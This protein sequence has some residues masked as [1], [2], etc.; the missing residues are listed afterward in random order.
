MPVCKNKFWLEN[1]SDLFCE[2]DIIPLTHMSL[3][4]QLNALS[5][6]IFLIT[7]II[8]PFTGLQSIY[9]FIAGIVFIIILF[10]S[11]RNM[12][13][14]EN[15][16]PCAFNNRTAIARQTKIQ[17]NQHQSRGGLKVEYYKPQCTK[18][19]K[20][21]NVNARRPD[22]TTLAWNEII[23]GPEFVSA[24][25]ALVGKP[26][27]RT[28]IPPIRVPPPMS[29]DW[30]ENSFVVRPGINS[31]TNQDLTRSGYLVSKEGSNCTD[32]EGQKFCCGKDMNM[33]LVRSTYIPANDVVEGFEIEQKL[34]KST[35]P[36]GYLDSNYKFPYRPY[37]S[38][39]KP[40]RIKK[41][42]IS[43]A[44]YSGDVLMADGYFPDQVLDDNLPSNISFGACPKDPEFKE[45]NKQ[46]FTSTLQPGVY[47]RNQIQEPI[48]SN[49]GI[50]FTQQF[51][52]VTCDKDCNGVTF[53][54]HDPN[55]MEIPYEKPEEILP[56]DKQTH[57]SDIYDPRFTGY[58]TSYRSYVEPVTGQVR[59]YY[60][61]VDAHKRPN[62]LCRSKVDFI[63][64]SLT[65][66]PIPNTEYFNKQNRYSRTIANDAFMDDTIAFR[67]DMQERLMRKANANLQQ[68]RRFPKHTRSVSKGGMSNPRCR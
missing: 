59:F 42:E 16:Q 19:Q 57:L 62:Y 53:I 45:Y 25:Q 4:R 28:M 24:N 31:A 18:T 46:T 36:I 21:C 40:E 12:D 13:C 51:E 6:L 58:G 3:A 65:T 30:K 37:G 39:G 34:P 29:S 41:V 35:T 49:I 20:L 68:S 33:E 7:L 60:D 22:R 14:K 61:D 56:Y 48:S 2:I 38:C 67:T 8:A 44:H 50:S 1:Y 55:I 26:A 32:E 43:D 23:P 10:Y 52:P 63:P 17:D 9:F 64:S 27:A 15:Y 47:T 66:Q 54:G 11:L 5:R